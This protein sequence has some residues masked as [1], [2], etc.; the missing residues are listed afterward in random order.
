MTSTLA[1]S[2]RVRARRPARAHLPR[3][4]GR[5][6]R[7]LVLVLAVVAAVLSP[8]VAAAP[9]ASA[10]P[11]T[12]RG[13]GFYSPEGGGF[14]LGSWRLAD[15][16]LAFCVNTD[17]GTPNGGEFSYADGIA[18][19]W[20]SADDAARLAYIS[21]NW[22]GSTDPIAAAAGQIATWTIT[23]LGRH[24]HEELAAK[25]GSNGEAVLNLARQMLD[26]T[27]R[28]A[29]RSVHATLDVRQDG[30]EVHLTPVLTVDTVASGEVAP[31]AG[32]HEGA[33]TLTGATFD[34]GSTT[35]L[36]RNGEPVRVRVASAT[37]IADVSASARFDG[38][39][40]GN[41]LTIAVSAGDTQ[42][43]LA[44]GSASAS[45]TATVTTTLA[46]VHAFQPVVSTRTSATV[47]DEGA[48]ISDTVV[49]GVEP[50]ETTLAE[51]PVF[52]PP[53]GPFSPVPVTVR[54]RLLGPFAEPIVPAEHPPAD[55]PVVCEVSLVISTGPGEYVTPE[56]TLAGP[57]TYVWVE[58]ISP[59]DTSATE[60]GARILPWTSAFGVATEITTVNAPVPPVAVEQRDVA[61]PDVAPPAP[62]LPE[63]GNGAA[64]GLHAVVLALALL[65]T[66]IACL[67][68]PHSQPQAR[69]LAVG[70]HR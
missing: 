52:G 47:A 25:A 63:T 58:T 14:W 29:S 33:L 31:P 21:R 19:G 44:A 59:A 3:Q 69:H 24:T 7:I 50:T 9:S 4:Q 43:L 41:A 28:A 64:S 42:N 10:V 22:A 45:A 70:H 8:L 36:V 15:G 62:T 38:L 20:Y 6:P 16:T 13:F 68:A 61:Q 32:A 46:S 26:E 34:D 57:G 49:V 2:A 23:G 39:G 66:G 55:A 17:R 37:A 11:V 35:A 5:T 27:E 54:S 12:G 56:C 67:R 53:G 1:S 30:D 48:A 60:G 40:Y 18:L 51:W 65:A